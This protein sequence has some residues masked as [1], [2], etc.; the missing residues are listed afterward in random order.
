[1]RLR[2]LIGCILLFVLL[3]PSTMVSAKNNIYVVTIKDTIDIGTSHYVERCIEKAE[4]NKSGTLIVELNTAGGDPEA[5]RAISSAILNT[6]LKTIAFVKERAWSAGALI[7]LSCNEIV[8]AP[9]SSI[10]AAETEIGNPAEEKNMSAL[11]T[12]F[13]VA[14]ETRNRPAEIV[15]GMV[16]NNTEIRGILE[17]GK[18]LTLTAKDAVRLGVADRMASSYN[19]IL[20]SSRFISVNLNVQTETWAEK[21]SRY[22]A[23]PIIAAIFLIL[24]LVGLMHEVMA[25][26]HGIGGGIALIFLGVFFG[27]H[28][29]AGTSS[30][31]TIM[32]FLGGIVLLIA[33]IFFIPGTGLAFLLGFGCVAG[34]IILSFEDINTGIWVFCI[35]LIITVAITYVSATYIVKTDF[36]KDRVVLNPELK[37]EKGYKGATKDYTEF[38]G[39]IGLTITPLR[40]VGKAQFDNDKL[41]VVTEGQFI[42]KDVKVEII[43]IEGNRIVVR[44]A[45]EK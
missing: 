16:N 35:V 33:E 31:I 9:A 34:S 3:M 22:L 30:P 18:F 44:E 40:P 25:P 32:L 38:I 19:E 41:D 7:A 28:Y 5:S 4:K 42:N 23:N 20:P 1:M 36:W 37:D 26:G 13:A 29:L 11:R 6:R 2:S 43:H 10:G 14:A 15:K 17:K 12:Q 39:K 8:M 45:S 21:L 24:G 27:A